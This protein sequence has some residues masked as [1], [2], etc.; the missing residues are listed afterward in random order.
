MVSSIGA[1]NSLVEA[2]LDEEAKKRAGTTLIVSHTECATV[3]ICAPQSGQLRKSFGTGSIRE[4]R[5]S[6]APSPFLKAQSADAIVAV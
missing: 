2:A 6:G 3:F 4:G 1:A 5:V